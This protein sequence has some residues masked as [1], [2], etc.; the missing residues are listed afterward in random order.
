MAQAQRLVYCMAPG[1]AGHHH[2]PAYAQQLSGGIHR[3]ANVGIGRPR[4]FDS[5]IT[6]VDRPPSPKAP[7][8]KPPI[9]R[10]RPPQVRVAGGHK[11]L[12]RKADGREFANARLFY[13]PDVADEISSLTG[14][15][16]S[17]ALSRD[18]LW[19]GSEFGAHRIPPPPPTP[20]P[21]NR[22]VSGEV[23]RAATTK[24]YNF[25]ADQCWWGVREVARR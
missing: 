6:F 11:A 10:M 9:S 23:L 16:R 12:G 18:R 25:G 24:G 20:A 15:S 21:P 17:A 2:V 19:P 13:G 22:C 8:P 4:T 3:V 7:Q 1:G 5:S 14:E